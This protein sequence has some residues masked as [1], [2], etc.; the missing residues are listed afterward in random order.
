MWGFQLLMDSTSIAGPNS[1][2]VIN[3]VAYWMGLDKFYMYSGTV[4]TL[5]C[6][7][8]QY[9]FNDFSFDQRYQTVAGHNEGYNE[10]WWF[11]VSQSEV[12][13]AASSNRVPIVDK[14][15]VYNYLERTWYYGSMS[16]T[17]WLDTGLEEFPLAAFNT[18]AGGTMLFHED[19]ND[20]ASTATPV[21]FDSFVS[22]SDFDI[23]DGNNFGFI[24][25]LIPDV[26]F[27]GST[28]GFPQV[29]MELSPRNF[30]GAPYH[31]TT[32]DNV[33]ST[34]QYTQVVKQYVIQQYTQ[35]IYSRVRGRQ[36][37][38]KIGSGG[39]LG[40]SWQLG[41]PRIDVRPDGKR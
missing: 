6:T 10:V 38:F 32:L 15:V 21:P 4:Q 17:Y 39:Q 13:A 30:P 20:D 33:Q 31:E 19:G 23:G 25:R 2:I 36:M 40:V 14:Y 8:R 37:S 34:Q 41:S 24:W 27:T 26:N 12:T 22:S 16:R 3:N 28:N 1:A 11:Y 5:P 7:L 35:Q 9:V 29:Y 18:E